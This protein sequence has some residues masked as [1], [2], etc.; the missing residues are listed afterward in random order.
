MYKYTHV[1][2]VLFPNT[3]DLLQSHIEQNVSQILFQ[4]PD[5]QQI[6]FFF[7]F[8]LQLS[9]FII[10]L[11]VT[12]NV[13]NNVCQAGMRI[14][15]CVVHYKAINTVT[16]APS[17]FRT[18]YS[19]S[20]RRCPASACRWPIWTNKY[21]AVAENYSEALIFLQTKKN[22]LIISPELISS[23]LNVV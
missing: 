9:D 8:F 12:N 3:F 13:T 20:T 5:S 10:L 14:E 2:I 16:S 15:I 21:E 6:F 23:C 1:I 7:V 4:R 22:H 19:L 11:T 17:F 18:S